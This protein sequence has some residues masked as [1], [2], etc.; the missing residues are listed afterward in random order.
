[1]S[2]E[3]VMHPGLLPT[4]RLPP[5]LTVVPPAMP[6]PLSMPPLLPVTPATE[7][8]VWTDI[9]PIDKLLAANIESMDNT[10]LAE[11]YPNPA[12]NI[13]YVSFKLHE[14]SV[15]KLEIFDQQGSII[16]T[17]IDNEN[18]GYGT[19][20]IPIDI[21]KLNIPSG[22]YFYRLTINNNSKTLKT[23]ITK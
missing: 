16:H 12:E 23:V 1:M 10:N 2:V 7:K 15:V 17:V 19:Y 9:T 5:L 20:I 3:K 8:S 18:R 11:A 21:D 14:L 22:T 6:V 13:S 4:L